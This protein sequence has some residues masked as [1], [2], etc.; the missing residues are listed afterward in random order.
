MV[1]QIR[2][3]AREAGFGHR[4]GHGDCTAEQQERSPD[5]LLLHLIPRERKQSGNKQKQQANQSDD[6]E[7]EVWS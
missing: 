6:A 4:C 1:N 3:P 2:Q 5:G 7:L